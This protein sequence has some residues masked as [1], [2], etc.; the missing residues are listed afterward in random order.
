MAIVVGVCVMTGW[1]FRIPGLSQLHPSIGTMSPNTAGCL[2]LT[3]A[4]LWWL[5]DERTRGWRK[6]LA[7]SSAWVTLVLSL[8]TIVIAFASPAAQTWL[9]SLLDG[10][11]GTVLLARMPVA[12]AIAFAALALALLWLDWEPHGWRVSEP[13]GLVAVF[14]PLLAAIAYLYTSVSFSATGPPR[15]LAFHALLL[16][17]GLGVGVLFARPDRG[18]TR[19]ATG[20]DAAGLMVRRLLP[21]A[22]LVPIVL[23]W[24]IGEGERAGWP[25]PPLTLPYYTLALILTLVVIV[26]RTATVLA[27]TDR[28]RQQAEDEIRSLNAQLER[29]VAERTDEL[30]AANR[31]LEAFSY[32]VSHDLRAPLRAISGFSRMLAEGSQATLG[33]EGQQHLTRVQNAAHRM[34]ELI[35]GLL[36]LSRLT[37]NHMRRETVDLS[38]LAEAVVLDLRQ[39]EPA[40]AVSVDIQPGLEANADPRLL[41]TVLEN[42]IGNAWKFTRGRADATITIAADATADGPIYHVRDNGAGFDMAYVSRLFGVF[43]RLHRE[44]EFEGTGIGLATVRRIV[45]RHG[46]HIWAEA[47]V[48][49]GATFSFTLRDS[50]AVSP[51][52]RAG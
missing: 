40:R 8:L 19:L 26:A 17:T 24:A 15:R 46:G 1:L 7:R 5:H 21:A 38:A 30:S 32:S 35:D 28:R 52:T 2:V 29:R 13:L 48:G 22:V 31:E 4:A 50:A 6:R 51:L 42:L 47:Q 16:I 14:T 36:S 23:G 12:T 18:L 9:G 43:E 34:G 45:E 41:R 33:A 3:G 11:V 20:D 37:R 27:H 44:A 25:P 49:R 39:A 10:A